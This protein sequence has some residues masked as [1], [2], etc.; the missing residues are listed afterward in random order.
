MVHFGVLDFSE[1]R[2]EEV[3]FLLTLSVVLNH[4]LLSIKLSRKLFL[5]HPNSESTECMHSFLL[6]VL[7][8]FHTPSLQCAP[9]QA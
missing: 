3:M 5:R 1:C 4:T 2:S 7:I 9:V 6:A 8:S